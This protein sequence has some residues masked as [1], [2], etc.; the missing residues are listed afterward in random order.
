[1]KGTLVSGRA[2]AAAGVVLLLCAV[3]GCARRSA[4]PVT[5]G[6][7]LPLTGDLAVYGQEM[8]KGIDLAVDQAAKGKGSNRLRVTV[9]YEDDRGDPKTSVTAVEKL[10]ATAKVPVIIGGAISATAVPC[11]PVAQRSHV[12]LFSPAATS[13][14][15]TGVSPYFFRNWPSDIYDGQAMGEFAARGLGFKRAAVLLVN[16][17]WGVAISKEFE[18]A[19]QA[20]GGK[21]VAKESYQQNA[22]DF[23][24]QLTKIK[25]TSPQ[26]VYL[27]GYLKELSNILRQKKE[28]DVSGT[29]LSAYGFYDPKLLQTAGSAAEGAVFTA[30]AY[31]PKQRK[32]AVEAYVKAFHARYGKDPDIWSAQ[33]YDAANIVL[34]ALR[35]G[36]RSGDELRDRIARVKGFDGVAGL[37]SFDAKGDVQK[38]LRLM[39][40]RGGKFADQGGR[41]R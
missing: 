30:P 18:R 8:K 33:A 12:V 31:D 38:P 21:I 6:A 28:L 24:A 3:A 40:V 25:S 22:T 23:R 36:G 13:P 35:E 5:I 14:K 7:V 9:L 16:N 19:F 39:T 10:I 1:M 41:G 29:A 4:Q 17:E 26:A 27:P 15:L 32:P 34:S 2:W 37:T 20:A 11:V